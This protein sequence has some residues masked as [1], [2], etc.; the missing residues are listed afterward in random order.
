[1][2]WLAK[3][4]ITIGAIVCFGAGIVIIRES[5]KRPMG[6]FVV[7]DFMLRNVPTE[8]KPGA[9]LL[10]EGILGLIFGIV[11]VSIA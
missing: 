6:R 11:S 5:L 3:T 7:R 4:S 2:L 8:K 10:I 1:M 9:H